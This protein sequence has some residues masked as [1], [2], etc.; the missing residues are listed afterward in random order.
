MTIMT[1]SEGAEDK[2]PQKTNTVNALKGQNDKA[3]GFNPKKID[4]NE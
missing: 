4:Q 3:W 1:Q 2:K